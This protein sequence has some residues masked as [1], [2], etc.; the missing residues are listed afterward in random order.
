[1]DQAKKTY[2]TGF[3]GGADSTAALLWALENLQDSGDRIV[4]VHF[5]HHLRGSESDAEAA[6]AA[7][8]AAVRNV[9]FRLVDLDIAPG[10]NLESRARQARLE[11]WHKLCCEYE[12]P[13]VITGHH[14]DDCIENMFLRIGRGSNVSGLTGLQRYAEIGGV[15][16]FRPLLEMSRAEI[17]IFL[18][19]RGVD[20]WAVDS[21]NLTGDHRRNVLR[22][23]ILPE[24]YRIFPGGRNAVAQT[25][26]N[27]TADAEYLERETH[28]LYREGEPETVDFWQRLPPALFA[29]AAQLFV[30]EKC[31]SGLPL[32]RS[33]LQRFSDAVRSGTGGVIPLSGGRSLRISGGRLRVNDDTP[34]VL[35][36]NWRE[37][38]ELR[39]GKWLLTAEPAAEVPAQAGLDEA[40]FDPDTLPEV[41]T[42]GA[43]EAGEKMTPFGTSRTVSI[44]KLRIDRKIPAFPA[45]PVV[46]DG[47]RRV[48]WVAQV[49]HSDLCKVEKKR[50]CIRIFVEKTE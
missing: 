13:V 24:L 23:Q 11:A 20:R 30:N 15:K 40:F 37:Q 35:L 43:A 16:F 47:A 49:R 36:W 44:K 38:P 31:G 25:L 7:E 9:E 50:F 22:N 45:V 18:H 5:N 27:L 26:D 14:Q 2:L 32:N 39:W 3:S 19:D 29:R 21:S 33:S 41:L 28:R 17:E 8:F 6:H 4:A 12:N 34:G 10:S 42:V 1:M 46:R 48:L